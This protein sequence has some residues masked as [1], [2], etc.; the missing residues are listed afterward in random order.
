MMKNSKDKLTKREKIF[1]YSVY[2]F[3][4]SAIIVLL[5]TVSLWEL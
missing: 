3:V 2:A 4:F 5:Y 1:I